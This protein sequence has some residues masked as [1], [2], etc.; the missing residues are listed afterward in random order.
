MINLA[1]YTVQTVHGLKDTFQVSAN[2]TVDTCHLF[3]T[4]PTSSSTKNDSAVSEKN[5]QSKRDESTPPKS[6]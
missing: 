3:V 6:R 1:T 5:R 4:G 2:G